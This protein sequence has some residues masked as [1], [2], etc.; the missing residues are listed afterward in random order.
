MEELKEMINQLQNEDK[1]DEIINIVDDL[2]NK[3]GYDRFELIGYKGRALN[4]LGKTQEAREVLL[5][6]EEQGKDDIV[7]NYR[8]AYS[9]YYD[10]NYEMIIPYARRSLEL[11]EETNFNPN[12]I[13]KDTI[14]IICFAYSNLYD[15]ESTYNLLTRYKDDEIRF[16]IDLFHHK[17]I[18]SSYAIGKINEVKEY[19]FE[20]LEYGI[21]NEPLKDRF[22]NYLDLVLFIFNDLNDYDAIE[23]IKNKYPEE[24]SIAEQKM[25]YYN[26]EDL[27]KIISFLEKRFGKAEIIRDKSREKPR[28]DFAIFPPNAMRDHYV[29]ST[30]GMGYKN[31]ESIPAEL[32]EDG[33]GRMEII[34][35]VPKNWEINS[36]DYEYNWPFDWAKLL[37]KWV[38]NADVWLGYGHTI[39]NGEPFAKNTKQECMILAV[40]KDYLYEAEEFFALKDENIIVHFLQMIP[41]YKEEMEYKLEHSADK[42]FSLFGKNFTSIINPKRKNYALTIGFAGSLGK[43]WNNGQKW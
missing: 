11:I 40:P 27:N 6:T 41:I 3:D 1:H 7:W 25:G 5:M 21:K 37:A 15:Y 31:M 13:I 38:H 39:P 22:V 9:F 30:I 29:I 18:Y 20:G 43:K 28:I 16:D 14:D 4:N 19:I 2:L 24:Y 33:L 8:M 10:D 23:N 42:L 17:L 35:S 36:N 34:F 12:N 32:M 26:E